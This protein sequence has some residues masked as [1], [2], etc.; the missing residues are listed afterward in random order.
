VDLFAPS[1]GNVHGLVRGGEPKLNIKR[2]KDIADAV[3][4]PLVLHGASGNTDEDIRAAI[5]A[6]MRIVHIN[7]ELRQAYKNC[8]KKGL[9]SDEL[10]PYKFMADGVEEMK[11]IVT[12]K[13]KVFNN[14]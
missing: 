4:V 2:I 10:A 1:V 5:D 11:E 8:A 13:L 9:S 7:T 12:K 3:N 6:G 14:I